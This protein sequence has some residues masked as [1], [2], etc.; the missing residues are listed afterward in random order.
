[1][2]LR[3]PMIHSPTKEV[4]GR[5]HVREVPVEAVPILST[6]ILLIR[7]F[8]KSGVLSGRKPAHL[9]AFL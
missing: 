1:M 4:S 9:A 6:I 7:Y 8:L 5:I 3:F 2:D